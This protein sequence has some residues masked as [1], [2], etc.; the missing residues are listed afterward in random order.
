M[1]QRKNGVR[2]A[3]A[4]VGLELHDRIAAR[5]VEALDRPDQEPSQALGEVGTAE[6]LDRLP[7]FVGALAEVDLPQ[8]GRE[9]GL[10]ISAAG[11]VLV[12]V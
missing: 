4:E 2:L 10:L 6:E 9:L 5:A 8:V 11:Y 12:R 1:I 3:A 7:V